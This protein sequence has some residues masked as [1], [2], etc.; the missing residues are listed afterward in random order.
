MEYCDGGDLAKQIE[1]KRKE[2][3]KSGKVDYFPED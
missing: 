3:E 1:T 2:N